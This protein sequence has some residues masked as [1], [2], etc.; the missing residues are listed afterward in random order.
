MNTITTIERST[1]TTVSPRAKEELLKRLKC[2]YYNAE[3]ELRPPL[4]IYNLSLSHIWRSFED[5][6]DELDKVQSEK[7]FRVETSAEDWGAT[8]VLRQEDLISRLMR[9]FD[10]YRS[11][12][13]C[14][15]HR[16]K[17]KD[18]SPLPLLKA[19]NKV[20]KKDKIKSAETGIREWRKHIATMMNHI[21]HYQGVLRSIVMFNEHISIPGYFVEHVSATGVIEPHTSVHPKH[22]G[23]YTAFS[24]NRDLRYLFWTVY[25]VSEALA[26]AINELEPQETNSLE[27]D[28]AADEHVILIAKR[29]SRLPKYLFRDET[30]KDFPEITVSETNNGTLLRLEYPSDKAILLGLSEYNVKFAYVGDG[31][32]KRFVIP[33]YAGN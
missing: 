15:F 26:N 7:K 30:E 10:D 32:S 22:K 4:G 8:L 27:V 18:G 5:V 20:R 24:F 33:Y 28:S 17:N 31:V 23:L 9:H 16:S 11:V 2:E 3:W 12:L 1:A 14:F 25:V 21:K 29:I 13:T 6:L 19:L